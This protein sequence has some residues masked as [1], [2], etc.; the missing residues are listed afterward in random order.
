MRCGMDDVLHHYEKLIDEGNDPV[1]D[2]P[3]L[4]AHMD[5]WDG[6]PFL[7]ALM[8]DGTQD[9]LEIGVGTG[10]LAMKTAPL[11][12]SFTGIDLS[13][14]TI[15][16]AG[17]HLAGHA[18]VRLICADFLA[19][20]TE[21]RLDVIYSSLTFQHFADKQQAAD[22]VAALLRPGG[23]AVISLDKDQSGVIDYGVRQVRVY[24][25]DPKTMSACLE[26]AG[27]RVTALQETERAY[28]IIAVKGEDS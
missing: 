1:M 27:L 5:G 14:K 4:A 3:E 21:A 9:V 8:L 15:G 11:C 18:H 19:W 26:L 28:I 23:R 22:R 2:P 10:R 24:P 20:D 16:R 17:E 6:H 13:P 25:D 12:R 7:A